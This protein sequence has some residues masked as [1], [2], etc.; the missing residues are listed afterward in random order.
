[1]EP[2]F[3][4]IAFAYKLFFEIVPQFQVLG[5]I[6]KCSDIYF[7]SFLFGMSTWNFFLQVALNVFK[8]RSESIK[9]HYFTLYIFKEISCLIINFTV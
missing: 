9:I 4:H 8:T 5:T 1:M 6:L 2:H 3:D 7:S